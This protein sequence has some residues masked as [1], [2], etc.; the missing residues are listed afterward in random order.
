MKSSKLSILEKIGFGSGDA[1]VNIVWSALA[2]IITFF[3]TDVYKLNVADLV[4]LGFLPRIIDA[5]AD[6]AMGIYTDRRTTRW[7]R[8]RPYLFAFA[9]PFGL[10]IAL[11]FT[12]PDLPYVGKLIWAYGTYT[13]MMVIFTMVTIP[14]IS[15]PGVITEDPQER[16]SANGYRLFFAKG[17]SLMVNIFVPIF[18]AR[19]G[20]A[21]IAEGYH[22]AMMVMAGLATLIFF[23]CFFTTKE[24][25]QHKTVH[26]PVSTQVKLL[27]HN[28]QWQLLFWACV[29]GT[30]GYI[31]RGSLGL[32]YAKYYLG[33]DAQLQ[34]TFVG[35]GIIGNILAMV[36]S[37]LL[38]KFVCKIQVF[39]WSQIIT[40]L[41]C[42]TM[43][44][45][46][47]QHDVLPALVIYFLI[48]LIV[49]LQGPVF[50]SAISEAV[51]YGQVKDGKRVAGLAFGGIS[52]A[53]KVGMGI[54][55]GVTALLLMIFQYHANVVQSQFTLNGIALSMTVISG[56]FQLIMGLLM[57]G[58]FITDTYYN[59]NIR[60][61]V[62][63]ESA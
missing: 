56:V 54:G 41:L 45:A 55:A 40:F 37:T 44:F 59:E 25:V 46:V 36:V 61:K 28:S 13:L 52:F 20:Q 30:T 51:D 7:G 16:L 11:T 14:Y 35:V 32:Y 38:T 29:I 19:W 15:L 57:Y 49:D 5:F 31:I 23:F 33:G 8:Y 21:H 50:W 62:T 24:R 60:A 9:I 48:N 10:S 47:G 27:V 39:R 42:V 2:I 18:A 17:A 22:V 4:L 6:V 3:Y 63:Q 53:Q 26:M 43:Y 1:A 12:T 58:Y 34:S